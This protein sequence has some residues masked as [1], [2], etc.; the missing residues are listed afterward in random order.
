MRA[1]HPATAEETAGVATQVAALCWR[2]SDGRA[3][4][5]LITSRDTG[6]WVIP[7]GWPIAGLSNPD[8]AAREAWE[9]AG[10]RGKVAA[11]PMGRFVYDKLIR[12]LKSKRCIVDVFG[13][14]VEALKMEFPEAEQRTRRWFAA[15]EAAT[16]VAE[17]ELRQ[18]LAD[19]GQDPSRLRPTAA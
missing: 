7:K 10:V 4:V 15:G 5:L 1:T 14:A 13:L 18:L 8:A 16:L 9:E 2:I 6:R 19:V 17:P 12:P 3:E 11:E